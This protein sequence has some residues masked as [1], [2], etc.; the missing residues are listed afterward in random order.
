MFLKWS[1]FVLENIQKQFKNIFLIESSE[2][3]PY[4]FLNVLET[5]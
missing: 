5:F 4:L 1:S 2:I 3:V